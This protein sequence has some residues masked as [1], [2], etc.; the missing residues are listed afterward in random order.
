M[1]ISNKIA[2]VIVVLFST[3]LSRESMVTNFHF[4]RLSDGTVI[5]HSHFNSKKH[6]H[7]KKEIIV[8]Y[9]Y[10][11]AISKTVELVNIPD[12]LNEIIDV[13]YDYFYH[14]VFTTYFNFM[15]GHYP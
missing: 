2:F 11:T 4:H 12:L 9:K 6:N 8:L 14:L 3:L 13:I 1:K 5:V 15:Y 10:Y 7:T